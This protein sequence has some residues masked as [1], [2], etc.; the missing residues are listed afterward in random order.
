MRKILPIFLAL[1]MLITPLTVNATEKNF[2]ISKLLI[3][4]NINSYGDL[5]VQEELTY[6]FSGDF[7]GIY[8]NLYKKGTPENTISGISIK[9]KNGLTPLNLSKESK[10]DTYEIKNTDT[11]TKIKIYSKS[12]NE[13]KTFIINYTAKSAAVKYDNF[14]QLYWSF[15]NVTNNKNVKDVELNIS[16]KDTKFIK[17][18]F[19]YWTYVD[20]DFNTN[21]GA[22]KIQIKGTNLSSLLGLKI[23][24]QPEFLNLPTSTYKEPEDLKDYQNNINNTTTNDPNSNFTPILFSLIGAVILASIFGYVVKKNNTKKFREDLNQYRSTYTFFNE[25]MLNTPPSDISP[26]LV[27][28]LYEC[29]RISSTKIT[30]IAIVSTLFYLSKKGFYT[31]EE[32]QTD[33][34]KDLYFIRTTNKTPELIHLVTLMDWFA[35]YE[36]NGKFS[37]QSVKDAISNYDNAKTFKTGYL[38]FINDVRLDAHNL[39]FF[40]QIRNKEVLSNTGYDELLS[41]KAYKKYILSINQDMYSTFDNS[42][43]AD[44][45][46]YGPALSIDNS[47]LEKLS[48]NISEA[49]KKSNVYT[50]T[51]NNDDY[52]YYNNYL[53]SSYYFTNLMMFDIINDNADKLY[54]INNDSSSNFTGGDGG[55]FGGFSDGSG[56]SGGGGSD[57]GAF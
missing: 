26:A 4:A 42:Y 17:D 7:N 12:S 2:T 48:K 35:S 49:Y 14:A 1:F 53:F 28:L 39:G 10:N 40:V 19:K 18:K 16:L 38:G 8:L 30:E 20:G 45:M 33:K 6:D 13:Q 41:W 57:S 29:D 36:E 34:H 54:N 46:I 37:L 47:I 9:D 24:F 23:N 31:I 51:L 21:Y 50:N 11:D 5:M 15:Y 43:L 25:D 52:F 56:F 22:D 44:A 32:L 55:G 3:N 27:N